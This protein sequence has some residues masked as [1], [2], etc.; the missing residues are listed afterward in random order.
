MSLEGRA[1]RFVR[2]TAAY[3]ASRSFPCVAVK[4]AWPD[5]QRPLGPGGAN[6]SSCPF[7]DI[8]RH[9][10]DRQGGLIAAICRPNAP[11]GLSGALR[12]D[13]ADTPAYPVYTFRKAPLEEPRGAGSWLCSSRGR[14]PSFLRVARR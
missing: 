11:S 7:S 3:G 1:L 6:W 4:V 13:N 14:G 5:R 8:G 12:T 10:P 2:R 9:R